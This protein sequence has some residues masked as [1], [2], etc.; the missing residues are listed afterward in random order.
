MFFF[1]IL[2]FIIKIYMWIIYYNAFVNC[3]HSK[4]TFGIIPSLFNS[5]TNSSSSST[6]RA[7][8][9]CVRLSFYVLVYVCVCVCVNYKRL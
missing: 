7:F 2:F 8:K 3:S 6:V 4:P 5:T 1:N 9:V